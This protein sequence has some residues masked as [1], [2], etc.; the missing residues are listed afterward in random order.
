LNNLYL[1]ASGTL[2]RSD[3]SL[4]FETASRKIAYPVETTGSIYVFGDAD[5]N[6]KLL[7]FCGQKRIPIHFFNYYGNHTGTFLPHAEQVSGMLVI[8]QVKAFDSKQ[9]RLNICRNLIASAGFNMAFNLRKQNRSPE[10]STAI[11]AA[12][13][14]LDAATSVE[15]ILGIEGTIRRTYYD[16]W[17]DWM[18]LESPFVRDYQPPSNPVNALVSFLNSLLYT[19]VASEIYRTALYPGISYLHSPQERRISLA[20]DLSEITKPVIVDRMLARLLN[21]KAVN[22]ADFIKDSNGVLLKEDSRKRMIQEWDQQIKTTVYYRSLKKNCSYRQ[23][24]GR[25]CYQ[26]IRYVLEDEPLNFFRL[27]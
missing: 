23:I 22:D 17:Q 6:T 19:T 5:L 3:N 16:G 1:N 9:K 21:T 27:G 8:R 7:N 4:C 25:D 15:E 11:K 24:I 20:L 14:K 26:L 12:L 18:G 13:E 2:S 10:R